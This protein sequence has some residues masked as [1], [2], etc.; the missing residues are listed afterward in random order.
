[1]EAQNADPKPRRSGLNSDRYKN[2]I[3]RDFASAN[4]KLVSVATDIFGKSGMHCLAGKLLGL[5][6]D[7]IIRTIPSRRIR[8]NADEI[9]EAILVISIRYRF[10][11]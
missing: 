2:R 5:D 11:Q 3:H 8:K 9:R 6:V 10:C 4:I 7:E 1:M